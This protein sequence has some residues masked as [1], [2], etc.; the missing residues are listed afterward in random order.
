[1]EDLKNKKL[2]KIMWLPG[3][4]SFIWEMKDETQVGLYSDIQSLVQKHINMQEWSKAYESLYKKWLN[5]DVMEIYNLNNNV[6]ARM[7]SE[8]KQFNEMHKC[9]YLIFYWFDEDRTN[10]EKAFSR[11]VSPLSLDKLI[12]LGERYHYLNRLISLKDYLVL[13]KYAN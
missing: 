6:N 9:D 1:M 13:P 5:E 4:E 2:L 10:S 8:I 11:T 12:D 7:L 3:E